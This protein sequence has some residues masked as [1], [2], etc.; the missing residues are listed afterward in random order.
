M[1]AKLRGPFGTI[2][3]PSK[4]VKDVAIAVGAY[5]A[6]LRPQGIHVS[7]QQNEPGQAAEGPVTVDLDRIVDE[8]DQP[9]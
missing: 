7:E 4:N 9:V 2:P 3:I 1:E 5:L 8:N 6:P